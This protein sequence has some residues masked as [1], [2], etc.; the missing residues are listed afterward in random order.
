MSWIKKSK[1]KIFLKNM[2]FTVSDK[3]RHKIHTNCSMELASIPCDQYLLMYVRNEMEKFPQKRVVIT[4]NPHINT[5]VYRN[6]CPA[7][8]LWGITWLHGEFHTANNLMYSKHLKSN[9]N[10]FFGEH[11]KLFFKQQIFCVCIIVSIISHL[12]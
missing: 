3:W 6:N 11:R 12:L 10:N 7:Q 8:T 9:Q 1:K 5:V 2:S 4:S